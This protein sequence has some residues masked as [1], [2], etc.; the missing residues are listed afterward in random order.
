MTREMKEAHMEQRDGFGDEEK[1]L[2]LAD[3]AEF[4]EKAKQSIEAGTFRGVMMS[5]AE[6]DPD[7]P[8]EHRSNIVHHW[9]Q[10]FRHACET[11]V[12]DAVAMWEEQN[13]KLDDSNEL[14]AKRLDDGGTLQ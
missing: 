4:I 6:L 3:L 2:V 9:R 12:R 8:D 14:R 10:G 11:M 7:N 1:R 13:G 5:F